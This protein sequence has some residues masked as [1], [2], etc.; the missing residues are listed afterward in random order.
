VCTEVVYRA[1]G[2]YVDLP[3][4]EIMG[5]KTLPALEIV[6]FWA[7]PVGAPQLEFVTFLDGDERTGTC[8]ERGPAE[9]KESIARPALTWLQ[10]SGR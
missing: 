2:S 1:L 4:V 9:L 6:R 7:S 3:L 10:A 5:R 8:V